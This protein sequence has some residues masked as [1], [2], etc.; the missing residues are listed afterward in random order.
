MNEVSVVQKRIQA[1]VFIACLLFL[2]LLLLPAIQV[3]RSGAYHHDCSAN[4]R[5]VAIAIHEYHNDYRHLPSGY[6]SAVVSEKRPSEYVSERGPHTGFIP[7]LLLYLTNEGTS[8]SLVNS[9]QTWPVPDASQA[10]QSPIKIDLQTESMPWWTQPGNL[11]SNTG[12]MRFKFLEC[13][14]DDLYDWDIKQGIANLQIN[15]GKFSYVSFPGAE[16]LGRTNYLGVAGAAGS[17]DKE[18]KEPFSWHR[19]RGCLTNRSKL[20]LGQL[21]VCDGTS[22]TMMLGEYGA[23]AGRLAYT[24]MGAGSLGTAYG[25]GKRTQKSPD[26]LT[27]PPLGKNAPEEGPI[28]Y[29]FSSQHGL[30]GRSTVVF[31]MADASVRRIAT[32]KATTQV[33]LRIERP[34]DW[35]LLQQLAGYRDGLNYGTDNIID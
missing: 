9:A 30:E 29:R 27:V 35:L 13:P 1:A 11:A 16:Q 6:Y 24:W 5:K 7:L 32:S 3:A 19:F 31:A 12:K 18:D 34:S 26:S 20:T 2:G 14:A 25:L 21:T 4:L 22:N 15:N 8:K 10:G 23:E 28:W 17:F 33:D